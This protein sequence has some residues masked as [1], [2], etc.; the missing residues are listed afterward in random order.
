MN[1][2]EYPGSFR[3]DVYA[4]TNADQLNVYKNDVLIQS[5]NGKNTPFGHLPQGPILIND[6]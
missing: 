1:V 4:F 6:F 2:G 5:F 3:G